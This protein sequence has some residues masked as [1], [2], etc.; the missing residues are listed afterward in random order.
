MPLLERDSKRIVIAGA[1]SLLGAEL[2][3]LLEESR[4]AGWDFR[5]VDEEIAAGI[6]TEAGGEPAV[7][8]PVEEGSFDKARFVFFCGSADFS[9]TNLPAALESGATIVDLSGGA[10]LGRGPGV[11]NWSV[12]FSFLDAPDKDKT[13]HVIPS[14]AGTIAGH[15]LNALGRTDLF[16]LAIVFHRPVS[17]AG[18][19]GIEELETQ[20]AQL[21]SFQSVGDRV[22]DT[23]VAYSLLDRYGRSSSENLRAV[24]DR[25][26][27][28][29]GAAAG[30]NLV[31]PSIQVLHAPLFYGYTFS[32]IAEL[33]SSH[34]R[35][36]LA[37][38]LRKAGL[39]VEEDAAE[40]LGNLTAAGDYAIHVK[41][42]E[43]DPA[44]PG[45]WWFW[46]AADNIRLPAW[47]AVK[48]AEKLLP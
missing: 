5:L 19:E 47:N 27:R 2:K 34:K 46:G 42:P 32:A 1:S 4:F 37:E 14:A 15:L 26:R 31:E 23:Q 3:S 30:K 24:T 38:N 43:H 29:A 22:F 18:R 25:I 7:I 44:Q 36:A 20:C 45:T 9:R 17:E 21:L 41:T 13:L 48:L 35:E 10:W 33:N 11:G 16:R 12:W 8:Q 39:L 28:E 6:L 40:P